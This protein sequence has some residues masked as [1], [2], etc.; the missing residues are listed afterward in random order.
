M[1]VS[2]LCGQLP[3]DLRLA[4]LAALALH[5]SANHQYLHERMKWLADQFDRDP[6]T[7]RR[8]IDQGFR[9]LAAYLDD[10]CDRGQETLSEFAPGGW[11]VESFKASLRIDVDPPQLIEERRIVAT[12][13]DLD[14]IVVSLSAPREAEV[15]P[16]SRISAKIVH[17][18]EIVEER[19]MGR[20]HARFVVRL[21]RPLTLGQRHE[22][23]VEFSS[24]PRSLIRPY[25]VYTPLRRCETFALSVRFGSALRPATL[26]RLNGVP[27]RVLDD[28]TPTDDLVELDSVGEA[29]L[30]F[31]NPVQGLS[32]GLQWQ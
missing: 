19:Q 4:V 1:C 26:W 25:Y 17:G 18:G 9:M 7:A 16:P 11:Y 27:A 28:F 5:E 14:E 2:E 23:G 8:R 31:R 3:E 30:Q 20:G 10:Q 32:Y 29:H 24:Y 21:P 6:R 12:V 15:E 22:Y 13:D